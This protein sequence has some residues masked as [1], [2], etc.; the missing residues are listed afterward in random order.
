VWEARCHFPDPG[1]DIDIY[2]TARD[3]ATSAVKNPE[4]KQSHF[5]LD[6][7]A[8]CRVGHRRRHFDLQSIH[9][10]GN[11]LCSISV[12][13]SRALLR[14]SDFEVRGLLGSVYLFPALLIR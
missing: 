6:M 8:L 9:L 3:G 1:R 10:H 4:Q 2:E 5:R 7:S 11:I 13:S 12:V 14:R